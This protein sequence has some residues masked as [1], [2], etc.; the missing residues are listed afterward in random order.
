MRIVNRIVALFQEPAHAR[1]PFGLRFVFDKINQFVRVVLK[2]EK[3]FV[4]D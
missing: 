2:I 3:L 1:Q 4:I